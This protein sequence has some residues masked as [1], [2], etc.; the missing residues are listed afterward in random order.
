[1]ATT[2]DLLVSQQKAHFMSDR[3]RTISSRKEALVTLRKGIQRWE[4]KI[5]NALQID[6]GKTA[7]ET[8]TTEISFCYLEIDYALKHL[9]QWSKIRKV[10]TPLMAQP[11]KSYLYP[12][13]FG[14]V[15]IISPWNYPFQLAIAPAI[16]AIAAG[17]C[18]IIKPSELAPATAR[19]LSELIRAYFPQ[20]FVAV[21]EGGVQEMQDL[22]SQPVDYIFYTGSPAVGK[23]VMNKAAERLIPVTLEL[24][25][26]SPVVIDA[27]AHIELAAK[28]IAWGKFL[29][30][31]QTCVAPDYLLV[32][33][34]IATV[35][36]ERIQYYI[37]K[38]YG[39]DPQKSTD[40]ARIINEKH[41]NRLH[42]YLAD[43]TIAIGGDV[44][45][46][47]RYISPTVLI[48]PDLN[49]AVMQDE[50]FGPILPV[51][52]WSNIS[53]VVQ[54]I[55]SRPKP[56]ALY[57]FTDTEATEQYLLKTT[58]AG[59]VCINDTIMQLTNPALPFGGVGNSGMGAYHG[60]YGFDTFTHEKAVLKRGRWS[61]PVLYPP[62]KGHLRWI[63]KVIH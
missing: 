30:A 53:E 59:S 1:M 11:G 16:A 38:F 35:L 41:W 54:I 32:H 19:V 57:I 34:E 5:I 62:Y 40:Y 46:A 13:P 58:S 7:F 51:L 17:N 15:T 44:D 12:E 47:D 61:L 37:H 55:H 50:I 31:G 48:K 36:I 63:R 24:G 60:K 2:I 23:I 21:L 26:K 10:N 3:T 42:S 14:V 33:E 22:L 29:N 52:T 25:G 49:A 45:K 28:R 6:F 9:Q 20:E 56:L 39:S 8:Y 43:G 18:V 4:D 27:S